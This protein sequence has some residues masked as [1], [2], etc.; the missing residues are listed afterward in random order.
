MRRTR[1]AR[2]GGRRTGGFKV[3]NIVGQQW[4]DGLRLLV[5]RVVTVKGQPRGDLRVFTASA[6]APAAGVSLTPAQLTE[7]RALLDGLAV[8]VEG[9][10]PDAAAAVEATDS[11]PEQEATT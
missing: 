1:V 9:Y 10:K 4:L 3:V 8:A 2:Q 5:A 7:L 11:A 6:N